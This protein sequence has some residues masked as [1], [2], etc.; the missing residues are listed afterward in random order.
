MRRPKPDLTELLQNGRMHRSVP[1]TVRARVLA[2][3]R[4]TA[5]APHGSFDPSVTLDVSSTRAP[6]NRRWQFP[7][8]AAVAV[9]AGG[10]LI[11]SAAVLTYR[12]GSSNTVTLSTAAVQTTL[13][14]P[15]ATSASLTVAPESN[16]AAPPSR[17]A[18]LADVRESYAAELQLLN[19]SQA[20][21][22]KGKLAGA[23][24]LLAEHARRFPRGRLAEEREALRVRSLAGLKR[25][26]DARNAAASFATRFPHSV[27]LPRV[28]AWV[29]PV[30]SG[31]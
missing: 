30:G 15:P 14:V 23:L 3:A 27:M 8:A 29:A 17:S 10:T 24:V 6:R 31:D 28:R 19:R 4:E 1:A 2:R 9:I 21:Y 13:P 18:R 12:L 22:A 11:A 26:I 7:F 5:S 20:A 25:T 16:L